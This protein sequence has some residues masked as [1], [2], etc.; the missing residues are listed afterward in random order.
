MSKYLPIKVKFTLILFKLSTDLAWK[1][2]TIFK[3][4]RVDFKL[5]TKSKVDYFDLFVWQMFR[6]KYFKI[7]SSHQKHHK[8]SFFSPIWLNLQ[9]LETQKQLTQPMVNSFSI[10]CALYLKFCCLFANF[11]RW[12]SKRC[13]YVWS[14]N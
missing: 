12:L 6:L 14:F 2:I 5:M 10:E 11:T 7:K 1:F 4:G 13:F 3:N 8:I 9:E